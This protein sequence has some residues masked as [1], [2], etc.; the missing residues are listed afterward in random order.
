MILKFSP[1]DQNQANIFKSSDFENPALLNGEKTIYDYSVTIDVT[2]VTTVTSVR[3]TLPGGSAVEYTLGSFAM[4]TAAGRAA[5][6]A[7]I[8]QQLIDLGYDSGVGS[9][10]SGNNFTIYTDLSEVVFVGLNASGNTFSAGASAVIGIA[11]A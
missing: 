9:K 7:A 4:G 10:V 2:S 11:N 3:M 8:N 5:L 6:V 1:T